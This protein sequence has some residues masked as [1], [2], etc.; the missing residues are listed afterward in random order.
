[1]LE[2]KQIRSATD[3]EAAVARISALLNAEPYSPDDAELDR[4]S[5]L[6][7]DYESEHFPI[8]HPSAAALLEFMLDQGIVSRRELLPLAG[9]EAGLDAIL[10]GRLEIPSELAQ[11]LHQHA[12]SP[13]ENPLAGSAKRPELLTGSRA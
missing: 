3:Y 4:L 6:V 5:D 12:G 10:A 1:M 7:A 8:P 13:V 9:G 11:L 2:I